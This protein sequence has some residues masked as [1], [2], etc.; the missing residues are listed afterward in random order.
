MAAK[1]SDLTG[2]GP[3]PPGGGQK[4]P[5]W[6]PHFLTQRLKRAGLFG[7]L[8]V[9]RRPGNIF[10]LIHVAAFHLLLSNYCKASSLRAVTRYIKAG[11]PNS[12]APFKQ[13]ITHIYSIY[14]STKDRPTRI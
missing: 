11:G 4:W 10:V 9:R 14:Y 6:G 8:S 1:P 12:A 7:V 3:W 13:T 2:G 5:D